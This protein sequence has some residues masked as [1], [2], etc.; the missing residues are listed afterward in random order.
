MCDMSPSYVR[1]DSFI[2]ATWLIHLCDMTLKVPPGAPAQVCACFL[3]AA[4]RAQVDANS[5]DSNEH[6]PFQAPAQAVA[7]V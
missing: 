6:A 5:L 3:A 7:P 4:G 2:S 1:G